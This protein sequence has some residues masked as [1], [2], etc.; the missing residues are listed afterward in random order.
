MQPIQ[1]VARLNMVPTFGCG[2]DIFIANNAHTSMESCSNL[3]ST[4]KH[5]DYDL[6]THEAKSFLAGSYKFQLSE[7]EVYFKE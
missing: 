5:S 7:I 3:G 6:G 4:Y 2:F 1:F